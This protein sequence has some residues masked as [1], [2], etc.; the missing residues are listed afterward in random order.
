LDEGFRHC[1]GYN[2]DDHFIRG[3]SHTRLVGAGVT[4]LG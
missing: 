3:F 1:S 4:D 2:W